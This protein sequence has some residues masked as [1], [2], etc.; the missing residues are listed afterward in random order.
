ME[1]LVIPQSFFPHFLNLSPLLC[2]PQISRHFLRFLFS[3][4]H[5]SN[6]YAK[7]INYQQNLLLLW[8][9]LL[10]TNFTFI[11]PSPRTTLLSRG[12]QQNFLNAGLALLLFNCQPE[13]SYKNV[14][15]SSLL[16]LKFQWFPFLIPKLF[17]LEKHPSPILARKSHSI[18]SW[19]TVQSCLLA[20]SPYSWTLVTLAFFHIYEHKKTFLC[21]KIYVLTGT[22]PLGCS[23]NFTCPG[24]PFLTPGFEV[25]P[26]LPFTFCFVRVHGIHLLCIAQLA[27]NIFLLGCLGGSGS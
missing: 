11:N 6:P 3:S 8:D 22:C 18:L 14:N 21:L 19:S 2:L 7:T 17:H 1:H 26:T 24:R 9:H 16:C 23:L 5:T 12:H 25:V 15:Y 4:S 20:F 10:L 13:W 27:F